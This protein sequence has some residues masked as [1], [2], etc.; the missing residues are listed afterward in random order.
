M[1]NIEEQMKLISGFGI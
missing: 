1:Q